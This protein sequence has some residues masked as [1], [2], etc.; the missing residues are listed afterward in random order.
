MVHSRHSTDV[1]LLPTQ[2]KAGGK[3]WHGKV[4]SWNR[5]TCCKSGG[6]ARC[7]LYGSR[8]AGKEDR[9]P[10]LIPSCPSC[11]NLGQVHK[12]FQS[13][14]ALFG[15][16][17][18]QIQPVNAEKRRSSLGPPCLPRPPNPSPFQDWLSE[19]APK[20]WMP[21]GPSAYKPCDCRGLF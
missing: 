18:L 14:A 6:Q 1:P 11:H 21:L 7:S 10:P 9:Q 17:S 19:R 8:E 15:D 20:S 13:W 4:A 2:H 3:E 5:L 16:Q 12:T